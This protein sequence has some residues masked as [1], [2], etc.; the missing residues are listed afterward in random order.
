MPENQSQSVDILVGANEIRGEG[1]PLRIS[2]DVL[3][4]A[5]SGK[6][7]PTSLSQG[8]KRI[9]SH[10]RQIVNTLKI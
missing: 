1:D 5:R 7:L 9:S 3:N 4:T 6:V 10:N 2:R 8:R